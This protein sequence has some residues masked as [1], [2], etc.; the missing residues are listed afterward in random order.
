[1]DTFKK[2]VQEETEQLNEMPESSWKTRD[3]HHHLKKHGWVLV[4]TSGNHDVYKHPNSTESIAV[5]RHKQLKA[6]LIRGI[7]KQS[8]VAETEEPSMNTF[9]SFLKEAVKK[10]YTLSHIEDKTSILPHVVGH[11]VAQ[12]RG[13]SDEESEKFANH[14][15]HRTVHLYNHNPTFRKKLHGSGNKGRDHLYMFANHWLD[16]KA[17]LKE[18][19]LNERTLTSAEKDKKEEIVKSMKKKGDFSKYG[20]RKRDVIYATATKLAKKVAESVNP[21][22]PTKYKDETIDAL[23]EDGKKKEKHMNE[24]TYHM[25]GTARTFDDKADKWKID[26]KHFSVNA[27]SRKSALSKALKHMHHHFPDHH[28]H[29]VKFKGE[30]I[31]EE[32]HA[33]KVTHNGKHIDTVFYGHHEEPEEVK[34]S[35]VNHDGYHPNI[36][37]T[38]ER[39]KTTVKEEKTPMQSFKGFLTEKNW[40]QGAIKHPGALKAKAKRAGETTSEFEQEH[41]HDSGTTGRQARLAITLKKLHEDIHHEIKKNKMK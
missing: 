30:N 16:G 4:R 32:L 29:E 14:V 37:V 41:K 2:F 3:V 25:H 20:T 13:L 23:G 40:I 39:K 26:E 10:H 18:D 33:Y 36:K 9:K 1:M 5:P 27:P 24:E 38:K 17:H 12:R 21:T 15:A 34:H 22:Y 7:L 19:Q 8:A 35:L 11:T 28:E 6:P 31:S